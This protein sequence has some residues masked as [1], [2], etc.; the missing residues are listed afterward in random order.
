[1]DQYIKYDVQFVVLDSRFVNLEDY[2][3]RF[4]TNSPN[5]PCIYKSEQEFV[6]KHAIKYPAREYLPLYEKYKEEINWTE[7]FCSTRHDADWAQQL[8]I[9]YSHELDWIVVMEYF[10]CFQYDW[11]LELLIQR[12]TQSL[13]DDDHIEGYSELFP[14]MMARPDLLNW[15][16]MMLHPFKEFMPIFEKYPERIIWGQLRI[17]PFMRNLVRKHWKLINCN[18]IEFNEFRNDTNY[19]WIIQI[20]FIR[21]DELTDETWHRLLDTHWS[22]PLFREHPNRFVSPTLLNGDIDYDYMHY[23]LR[24]IVFT[25]DY[26]GIKKAKNDLHNQIIGYFYRPAKIQKWI[27]N[28]NEAEDYDHLNELH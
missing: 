26:E 16:L 24:Q 4:L 14:L 5:N 7:L 12:S 9:K 18:R 22:W 3:S 15:N 2:S 23:N 6:M 13:T 19:D 11:A 1:M 20:L 17:K 21:A 25:Y 28:G 10:V 8:F 27:N